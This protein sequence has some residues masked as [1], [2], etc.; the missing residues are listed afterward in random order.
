MAAWGSGFSNVEDLQGF[1]YGGGADY[2]RFHAAR[3]TQPVFGSETASTLT[4][5]GEYA[6]NKERTFVSSYN[7]TD[8]SWKRDCRAAV[9]VRFA[10]CGPASTT[11]ASRRRTAGPASIR[12]S[13]FWT[14]AAFPRTTITTTSRG[15]S[16]SPIVHLLPHWNWP[17]KE[18]QDIRVVAF[19]NCARVELWLNGHSLGVKDMPRNEHLEWTVK[20]APG[21]LRAKGYDARGKVTATD[22]GANDRGPGGPALEQRPHRARRRW[23][24]RGAGEGGDFG[25]RKD[26]SSPR[27]TTW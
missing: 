23:R 10:S 27:R 15:G 2:D 21:T 1:N 9:D 4:T 17:G 26:G 25:C 3:P 11:R 20:Y 7:M 18:G 8:G 14:C 12:T 19:S 16:R 13:A 6:D 24:G 5:R 22:S